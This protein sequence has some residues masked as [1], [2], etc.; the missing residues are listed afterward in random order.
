GKDMMDGGKERGRAVE[1]DVVV[2]LKEQMRVVDHT[3]RDFLVHLRHG[4]VEERHLKMLRTLVLGDITCLPTDFSKGPWNDASLVT[5]RHAVREQWNEEALQKHCKNAGSRLYVCKSSNMIQKR[6]LTLMEKYA[7]ALH[8]GKRKSRKTLPD[9]V[10]LAVG[11][12][13]LV[14]RNIETDLDITNG[15]RGEIVVIVLDPREPTP[16]DGTEIVHLQYLPLYVLV[17]MGRTRA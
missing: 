14:T 10:E 3:W 8:L 17:Q 5:P 1:F 4:M 11:M 7:L 15:A 2:I 6:S 12:K 13:V 9:V 16:E